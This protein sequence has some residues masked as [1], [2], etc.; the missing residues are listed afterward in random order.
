[1]LYVDQP[2]GTGFSYGTDDATSTLTAAPFVW[3][4]MQAFYTAFPQYANR[5]FG[6]FTESYGG[7]YG[8]EFASYFES[9]NVAG[10]GQKINL[11]ALG[12][13]NG[14]IDPAAQYKAYADFAYNN[15]YKRLITASQYSSYVGAYQS[16]CLPAMAKCTGLSGSNSACL[17][18]DS[19]CRNAV[20]S[21]IESVNDFDVYDI[22]APS[23]D[24]NPPETYV[25]Y[26]ASASVV[27]AIGAKSTYSECANGPYRKIWNTGDSARS[28]LDT[29]ATVVQSG[30]Q[31]LVW[32]GDADWICNWI[33]N[34]D[35]ANSVNWSGKNI[36][37]SKAVAP[38]TVGGTLYGEFKSVG[39][40]SWLRV[41]DA[42]HEV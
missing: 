8:P 34:F 5:D 13:N 23:V 11:V 6:L 36:F 35:V 26:L 3:L 42:G 18:A 40:L 24:P 29:L 16:K 19:T 27:K 4:F 39:N 7:H 10:A 41:Y 22:R 21:P 30:I 14:W 2:I 9:Q 1:M 37:A 31:V 28:Y 15:T 20:E 17:S 32:A 12:I 38:Y 25:T 33:G